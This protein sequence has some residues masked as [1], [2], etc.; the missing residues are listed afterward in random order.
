MGW[1]CSMAFLSATATASASASHC[2][3]GYFSFAAPLAPPFGEV[4]SGTLGFG[5]FGARGV[6][7]GGIG[8]FCFIMNVWGALLS[9]LF[10]LLFLAE[11]P[12]SP[13]WRS[14]HTISL[15]TIRA[16]CSCSPFLLAFLCSWVGFWAVTGAGRLDVGFLDL[17]GMACCVMCVVLLCSALRL[18]CMYY[19]LP[20]QHCL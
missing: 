3:I 9:S 4:D 20:Y 10:S 2:C 12:R 1:G 18:V 17:G 15:H 19:A 7:I 6:H 5:D 8:P 11:C 13:A 16:C 14:C